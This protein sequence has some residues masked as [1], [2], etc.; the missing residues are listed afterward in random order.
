M[1]TTA[2]NHAATEE[3]VD[4]NR[5]QL[6]D[7]LIQRLEDD[8]SHWQP[9]FLKTVAAWPKQNERI[10][11]ET[12][13]YFIGGEAFNWK[14]LAE[15]IATQL[16]NDNFSQIRSAD[17]FEWLS[18]TG[19]FGGIPEQQFQRILG[20]DAWRAHLNYFYGV[21]IEQCLIA[22]VQSRIQKRRYSNGM[23]PSDDAS[24]RA[25]LGLYEET[26]ETLWDQFLEE[27][28]VCL[29][30]L[31]AESPDETRTIALEEEFTYWLFKR[32]IEYTNAPQVAAETQRGLAMLNQINTAHERRTRML[33]DQN[34]GALLEFKLVKPNKR[35]AL[36]RR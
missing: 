22:A 21:H 19:V 15:R 16:A 33:K 23:P 6:L 28:S 14:R 34:G 29:A 24:E 26:E 31:I 35:K 36:S 32:R 11:C 20:V 3:D 8:A 17:L 5:R 7:N 10:D 30:D 1:T 2:A 25:Y 12:F 9:T 4:T 18:T 27:N 13:H